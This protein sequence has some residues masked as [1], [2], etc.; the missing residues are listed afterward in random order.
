MRLKRDLFDKDRTVLFLIQPLRLECVRVTHLL[1]DGLL[2]GALAWTCLLHRLF[3]L[4]KIQFE[5][6][7]LGLFSLLLD[8]R[9]PPETSFNRG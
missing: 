4:R 3:F 2:A 8:G 6:F 9:F 1:T 5:S 7:F